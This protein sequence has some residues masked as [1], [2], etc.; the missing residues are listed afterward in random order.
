MAGVQALHGPQGPGLRGLGAAGGQVAPAE[1]LIAQLGTMEE[2]ARRLQEDL[3]TILGGI[4]E[5]KRDVQAA[6]DTA[7]DRQSDVMRK[8]AGDVIRQQTEILD[9]MALSVQ[10]FPRRWARLE[11]NTSQRKSLLL[12]IKARRRKEQEL[13]LD[14]P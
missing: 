2:A 9:Q 12:N 7:G 3:T 6:E 5:F 8:E 4:T 11:L 14:S 1:P 13:A 10:A